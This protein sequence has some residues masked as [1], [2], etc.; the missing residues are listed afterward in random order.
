MARIRNLMTVVA[1]ASAIVVSAAP[2][3][4]QSPEQ[5]MLNKANSFRRA[6]GLGKLHMS[7]SLM[8]SASKYAHQLMRSGYFGHSNRIHASG[9]YRRLGEI[10]EIQRGLQPNI[11]LAFNTWLHSSG[12]RA[13]IMDRSF[14]YAGA[15]RAAGRFH[16]HNSTIWVMH[17]GRP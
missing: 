14:N 6:H 7:G 16:G 2:A 1:I 5:A 9:R 8:G 15:G 11:N 3:Q 17:F 13:I 10:L 4:A 12:H